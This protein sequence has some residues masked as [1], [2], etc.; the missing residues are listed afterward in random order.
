MN[1]RHKVIC[2]A[3][4]ITY[5]RKPFTYCLL[6]V[7][8]FGVKIVQQYVLLIFFLTKPHEH[9]SL[10]ERKQLFTTNTVFLIFGDAFRTDYVCSLSSHITY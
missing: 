1:T 3:T 4:G 8:F 9:L 10:V 2:L 6:Y 7:M 5:F